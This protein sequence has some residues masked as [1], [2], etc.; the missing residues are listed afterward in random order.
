VLTPLARQSKQTG[1]ISML[2]THV[3]AMSDVYIAPVSS[4]NKRVSYVP[5]FYPHFTICSRR[6]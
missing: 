4:E 6:G 1:G 2:H 3:P 5:R